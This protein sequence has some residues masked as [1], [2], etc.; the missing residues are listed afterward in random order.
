ML[1]ENPPHKTRKTMAFNI[2]QPSPKNDFSTERGPE[3]LILLSGIVYYSQTLL[4]GIQQA[5]MQKFWTE[6]R[7]HQLAAILKWT[8]DLWVCPVVSHRVLAVDLSGSVS[9]K[10]GPW[11]RLVLSSTSGICLE[12]APILSHFWTGTLSCM[13]HGIIGKKKKLNSCYIQWRTSS[14][15]HLNIFVNVKI[16]F[17]ILLK[18]CNSFGLI[19]EEMV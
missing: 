15:H 18:T 6:W 5:K 19:D 2:L 14:W 8:Q 7:M 3:R 17:S 9:L 10:V 11:I 4:P 12:R 13:C 1:H 16:S